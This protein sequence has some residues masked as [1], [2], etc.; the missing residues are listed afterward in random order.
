MTKYWVAVASKDHVLRGIAGGFCQACH[1]K[2]HP[3]LRMQ[4]NDW[5]IYYSPTNYFSRE[6][7]TVKAKDNKLQ[8]FTA[9]GQVQGGNAYQF[10]MTPSFKPFRKDVNFFSADSIRDVP[11][12]Q[13]LEGLEFYQKNPTNWGLIVRRGFFEI[14]SHDFQII[15]HAMLDKSTVQNEATESLALP[16]VA[17]K[18]TKSAAAARTTKKT[19]NT[20]H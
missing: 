3:L 6:H 8:S 18:K 15:H 10:E 13:I 19:T 4:E 12:N 14:S 7:P 2:H 20:E 5:I 16:K 9:I 1:G 11:V 17:K